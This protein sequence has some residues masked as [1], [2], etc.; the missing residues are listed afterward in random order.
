MFLFSIQLP[1]ETFLILRRTERD[2]IKNVHW[3]YVKYVSGLN[4]TC[5]FFSDRVSKNTQNIKSYENPPSGSRVVPSGRMD[6]HGE[7]TVAFRN[8]A[9]EPKNCAF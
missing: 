4:E 6:I 7:A 2:I 8:F 1:S 3:S 5:F 9:N